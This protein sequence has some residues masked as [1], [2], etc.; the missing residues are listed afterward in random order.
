MRYQDA[1]VKATYRALEDVSRAALAV[2]EDKRDWSVG[3]EARSVLS[4]MREIALSA[5][6]FL[7]I[8]RDRRLPEFSA[9]AEREGE[10]IAD[11]FDSVEKCIEA[12]RES[13]AELCR[14]ISAVRD[15]DLET[16]MQLP[17]GGG[18]VLTL[19]EII[20]LH[21]W[22]MVYH[23]GQINYIQLILGDREMH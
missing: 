23:L 2:P 18:M 20:E 16:E 19:A 6:W 15:E 3:G 12:A 11:T 1:V 8:V 9:H 4:Q 10:R 14:E 7:P 5:G 21:R 13:T 22:N 17:F